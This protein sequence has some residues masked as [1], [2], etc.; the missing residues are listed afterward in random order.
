MSKDW[1]AVA[2]A[3]NTRMD[4]LGMTQAE[5][6]RDSRVA[7]MTV[8]T[9][10]KGEDRNR[11]PHTLAAISTALRWPPGH[12]ED[13]ADGSAAVVDDDVRVARLESEIAEL[14]ERVER[15]EADR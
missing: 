8:Q 10:R 11:S 6:V 3:V 14:R 13:I 7:P 15:L 1:Q 12:L 9:I 4:E 2:K 5:L